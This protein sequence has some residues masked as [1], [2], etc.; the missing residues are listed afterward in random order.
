MLALALEVM[1]GV[2]LV[3]HGGIGSHT[4]PVSAPAPRSALGGQLLAET[5]ALCGL[6][7]EDVRTSPAP[8]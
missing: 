7:G 6:F 1:L 2:D 5:R 4:P 3:E 8:G